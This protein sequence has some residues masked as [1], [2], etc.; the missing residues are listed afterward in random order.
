VLQPLTGCLLLVGPELG[1]L[2]ELTKP[3]VPLRVAAVT[4]LKFQILECDSNSL[5]FKTFYQ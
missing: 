4:P 1:N 2:P 5:N 3:R